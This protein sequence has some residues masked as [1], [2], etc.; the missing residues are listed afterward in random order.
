MAQRELP[1]PEARYAA[2][3]DGKLLTRTRIGGV[4][5]ECVFDVRHGRSLGRI[6]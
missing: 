5:E 4:R 2:A 1:A 3:D 6:S